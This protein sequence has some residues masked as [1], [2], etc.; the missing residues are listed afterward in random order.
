MIYE[1]KEAYGRSVWMSLGAFSPADL[2]MYRG[3]M[4][5]FRD[6]PGWEVVPVG[7]DFEYQ[8]RQHLRTGKIAGVIGEFVGGSWLD[9]ASLMGVEAVHLRKAYDLP[10]LSSAGL[11]YYQAGKIAAEYLLSLGLD[12]CEWYG[13]CRT[14]A[15]RDAYAGMSGVLGERLWGLGADGAAGKAAKAYAVFER[16]QLTPL[17]HRLR[18]SGVRIPQEVSIIGFGEAILET[19]LIGHEITSVRFPWREVGYLAARLLS[20]RLSGECEC[21]ESVKVPVI[22]IAKGGSTRTERRSLQT[23]ER[24]LLLMQ[25][26]MDTV[27]GVAD[28]ARLLGVSR[29]S[30]ELAFQAEGR[31]SPYQVYQQVRLERAVQLM[32][33]TRLTLGDIAQACG[34]AS[35]YAFSAAFKRCKGCSPR[36]FRTSRG[37]A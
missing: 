11:D 13:G 36:A 37:E 9:E 19:A 20:R 27:P 6:M 29:R 1:V 3:V 28:I 35:L 24:A 33:T 34:Y 21:A 5:W 8:M 4:D 14:V 15:A 25:E 32:E 31:A 23:V 16:S 2:E 22:E 12:H 17:I 10:G 18:G 7:M 26:R 30:L